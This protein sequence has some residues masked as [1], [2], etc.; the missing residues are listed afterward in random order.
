[1]RF[2]VSFIAMAVLALASVSFAQAGGGGGGGGRRQGGGFGQFGRGGGGAQRLVQLI[3]S[4]QVQTELK[5]TDD[6][7]TKI[8]ALPR[9]GG[10]RPG[11]GGAGGNGGG[12]GGA[13]AGGGQR[14][15][16]TPPTPEEQLKQ[17]AEDKATTSAI[18]T[19]EQEKRLEELRVQ[20]AG[21]GAVNLPDVQTALDLTADQKTKIADLNTKMREATTNL[22]EK[23]R[24]GEVDRTELPTLMAKNQE[25]MKTEVDKILTDPQ[26]AKLKALGGAELKREAPQ[27][28]GGGN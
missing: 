12:G 15:A 27:R 2:K 4:T 1:M 5:V 7:K 28:P 20:W 10:G 21:A 25:I 17:L 13:A 24:N 9:A 14:P 6:Q 11:G 8:D 16:F 26:K 23:M 19:P 18:L 3:R 22:M